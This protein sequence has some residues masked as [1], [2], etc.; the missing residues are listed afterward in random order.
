VDQLGG[1]QVFFELICLY[2]RGLGRAMNLQMLA[3]L[4][5]SIGMDKAFFNKWLRRFLGLESKFDQ[6]VW[7]LIWLAAERRGGNARRSHAISDGED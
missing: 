5:N 2:L 1:L 6:R 3:W 7:G 4:V